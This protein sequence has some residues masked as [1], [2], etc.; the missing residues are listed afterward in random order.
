MS[1]MDDLLRK[2]LAARRKLSVKQE[3][4]VYG[5]PWSGVGAGGGGAGGGG[6]GGFGGNGGTEGGGSG[7]MPPDTGPPPEAREQVA[8]DLHHPHP[9][10]A[11]GEG[12]TRASALSAAEQQCSAICGGGPTVHGHERCWTTTVQSEGHLVSGWKCE[13]ECTCSSGGIA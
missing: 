1:W 4:H 13:F 11:W 10:M 5:D 8:E 9:V 3:V 7:P 6:D 2:V 12:L